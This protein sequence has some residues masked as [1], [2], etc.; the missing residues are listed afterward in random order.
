MATNS[1]KFSSL[2]LG[3]WLEIGIPILLC[4]FEELGKDAKLVINA[5]QKL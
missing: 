2:S 5:S 4:V 3:L 1:D